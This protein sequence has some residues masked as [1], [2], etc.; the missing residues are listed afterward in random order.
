MTN[1][2]TG[3]VSLLTENYFSWW[4]EM[5]AELAKHQPALTYMCNYMYNQWLINTALADRSNQYW[6]SEQRD[7][8]WWNMLNF[9]HASRSCA[10]DIFVK[11]TF[12]LLVFKIQKITTTSHSLTAGVLSNALQL[13]I[14]YFNLSKML[15]RPSAL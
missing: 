4:D 3:P 11:N 8:S 6:S 7:K 2:S 5:C 14:H 12:S 1:N 9:A 15:F 10:C 13:R